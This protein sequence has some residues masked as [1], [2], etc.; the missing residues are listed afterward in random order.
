MSEGSLEIREKTKA[1]LIEILASDKS[2]QVL[3]LISA[4]H[5]AKLKKQGEEKIP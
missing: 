4:E 2:K 5:L 1:I 3:R